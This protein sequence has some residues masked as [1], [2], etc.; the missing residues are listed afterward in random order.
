MVKAVRVRYGASGAKSDPG[1]AFVLADL[2]R[3][4]HHR[5]APLVP[6]GSATKGLRALTRARK[7]LVEAR[8][9]L[10]NQLLAQLGV[11]F[12]GRGGAVRGPALGR[13]EPRSC[14]ATPRRPR[15]PRSP[16]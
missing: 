3:T 1:D 13:G 5:L 7:D 15:P 8:V 9:S 11:C 12:P 14:A 16:R 10:C 6:D 2:L 4:D